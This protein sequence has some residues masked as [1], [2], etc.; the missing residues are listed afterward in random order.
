M[1]WQ[2]LFWA[3]YDLK[4]MKRASELGDVTAFHIALSE[5]VFRWLRILFAINGSYF[6]GSKGAM[7]EV[8]AFRHLPENF[9]QRTEAM[10]CEALSP[11][12]LT[13]FYG[14]AKALTFEIAQLGASQ[15]KEEERMVLRGLSEW[16]DAD[17]FAAEQL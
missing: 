9:C 3:R 14:R 7:R 10:V 11:D 6:R 12:V 5:L 1:L 8:E 4:E 16:P 2:T 17:S 13:S 15:G